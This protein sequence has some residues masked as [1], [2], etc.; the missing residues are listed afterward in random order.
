V[1]DM[2]KSRISSVLASLSFILLFTSCGGGAVQTSESVKEGANEV[3]RKREPVELMFWHPNKD[4]PEDRFNREIADPIKKKF[5]HITAKIIP[6]TKLSQMTDMTVGGQQV[7]IVYS[8]TGQVYDAFLNMG[9]YTDIMPYVKKYNFDLSKIEPKA[10]DMIKQQTGGVLAGIPAFMSPS[11]LYYNKDLFDKFGVPYPKDGMTWDDVY[12]TARKLTHM[13]G[14]TAYRGIVMSFGH[15]AIR[16]QHSYSLVDPKTEKAT[17][18]NDQWKKHIEN[19]ARFYKLTGYNMDSK[20]IVTAPQRDMFIKDRTAAMWLPVSTLHTEQELQGMNWDVATFPMSKEAPGIGPQPY[21]I[22]FYLTKMSKVQD[23]A[24]EVIAYLASEEFQMGIVRRGEFLTALRSDALRKAFGQDTALYKGK[25]IS[26]M[27]PESYAASPQLT[28]YD[29]Q[30]NGQ[31][32]SALNSVILTGKDIN[33]AL[34]D[35]E[36]AANKKIEAMKNA[37]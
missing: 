20:N 21:P 12:E 24:F 23:Q 6:Y 26:A 10:L 18:N 36:E 28:K 14:G 15:V 31:L 32:T 19:I 2:V 34:R 5:P 9:G 25:N 27:L 11:P 17:L 16:Q 30:V 3:L 13:E 35:A 33:S 7:D 8:S 37:K 4:W 1:K 29:N 22:S